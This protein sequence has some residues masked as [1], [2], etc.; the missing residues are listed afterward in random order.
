MVATKSLKAP[1]GKET[2]DGSGD[3]GGH[4]IN[5]KK[6]ENNSLAS[7]GRW[8]PASV[9]KREKPP[10]WGLGVG[11]KVFPGNGFS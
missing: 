10:F 1:K 11:G 2:S 8:D 9:M 3:T 6:T 4:K 5:V 7:I